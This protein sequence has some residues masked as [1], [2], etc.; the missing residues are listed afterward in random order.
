[1]N[2]TVITI[3][4]GALG[5]IP[6]DIVRGLEGLEIRERAKTTQTKALLRPDRIPRRVLRLEGLAQWN[7]IS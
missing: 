3:V 5:T 2:V 6:K 1:M 4:N 7:T